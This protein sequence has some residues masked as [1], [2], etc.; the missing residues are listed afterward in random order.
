MRCQV[1]KCQVSSL[2]YLTPDT[3]APDTSK[4]AYANSNTFSQPNGRIKRE[5]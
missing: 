1:L 2:N 4:E 5:L 3:K